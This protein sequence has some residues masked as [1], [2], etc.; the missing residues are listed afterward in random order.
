MKL[1]LCAALAL[2][3]GTA[4]AEVSKCVDQEG[5]MLLTDSGCPPDTH[6]VVAPE[7]PVTET[8]EAHAIITPPPRS[9]W[10]DLPRSLVRKTV[11]VDA[12]TL[13]AAYQSMQMSDELRKPRR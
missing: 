6:E 4:T 5:H 8:V 10:A 13:Q 1:V 11:S 7:P 12:V 9:R 2:V 3:C